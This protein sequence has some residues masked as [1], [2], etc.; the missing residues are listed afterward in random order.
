M[1]FLYILELVP[2]F[3]MWLLFLVHGFGCCTLFRRDL[4]VEEVRYALVTSALLHCLVISVYCGGVV[5][6]G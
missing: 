5:S 1:L 2:G 3:R 6:C 4:A